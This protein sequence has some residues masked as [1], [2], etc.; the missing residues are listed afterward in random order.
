MIGWV[1][2]LWDAMWPNMFA[3]SAITLAAVAISHFRTKVHLR[4]HHEDLKRH[5]SRETGNG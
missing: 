2:L 3:P 5:V 1:K 4:R